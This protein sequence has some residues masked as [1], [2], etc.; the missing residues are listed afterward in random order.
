MADHGEPSPRA[1]WV[2]PTSSVRPLGTVEVTPLTQGP[3]WRRGEAPSTTLDLTSRP[4]GPSVALVMT[5]DEEAVQDKRIHPCFREVPADVLRR[6]RCD[7]EAGHY[8][9]LVVFKIAHKPKFVSVEFDLE[10]GFGGGVCIEPLEEPPVEQDVAQLLGGMLAMIAGAL[11]RSNLDMN[12]P[13]ANDIKRR[14]AVGAASDVRH[15]KEK[16]NRDEDS[17]SEYTEF[18]WRIVQENWGLIE[19]LSAEL[20]KHRTLYHEEAGFIVQMRQT[21]DYS[22]QRC[23]DLYRQH[24]IEERPDHPDSIEFKARHPNLPWFESVTDFLARVSRELSA[25]G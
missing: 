2:I 22:M 23:L 25:K 9:L 16:Y 6:E 1:A 15:L 12:D 7:H 14:A 17:L 3:E 8:V 24:R 19:F 5:T 21:G 13:T 20:Y 4:A 18:A 10:N 11:K